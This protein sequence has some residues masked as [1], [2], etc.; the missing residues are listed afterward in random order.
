MKA[1]VLH[2]IDNL[3]SLTDDEVPAPTIGRDELLVQAHAQAVDPVDYKIAAGMLGSETPL[4]LGSTVAGEVIAVGEAVT[5]FK[6]GDRI[7][8]QVR[9]GANYAEQVA[10]PTHFAA[11]IPANV[12]YVDAAS[13]VLGGQTALQA[14]NRGLNVSAG[15][16]V[17][18]HGGPGAVGYVA[19]QLAIAAGAEVATTA[20]G[21]GAEM[22]RQQFPNVQVFDYRADDFTTSL[23]DFD[24]VLDTV[25]ADQVLADSYKILK[26]SGKLAS[27]VARQS[28]DSR[29]VRLINKP[30]GAN[31][32]V[33]FSK[34]AD[35]TLRTVIDSTLP[36]NAENVRI[37]YAKI[38]AGGLHG[39]LVFTD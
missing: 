14:I 7:A 8:A 22:L 34:L 30:E 6:V 21:W 13:V 32:Q 38:K 37:A 4:I 1:V 31:L 2:E 11:I 28:D 15:Q 10:V 20:S 12:S 29:F 9:G 23:H 35:G 17:L 5:D 25:G 36:L 3:D 26:P 33:L 18:I 27:V 16:K 24:G 39:K 19:V